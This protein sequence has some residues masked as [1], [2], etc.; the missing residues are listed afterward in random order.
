MCIRDRLREIKLDASRPGTQIKLEWKR[1]RG[2]ADGQGE[3]GDLGRARD[4]EA[5]SYTHLTLP[6]ICSV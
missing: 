3:R 6:T 2:L 4:H 5:V 1:L